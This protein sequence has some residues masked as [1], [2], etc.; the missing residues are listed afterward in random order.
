MANK[1]LVK[2]PINSNQILERMKELNVSLK[3]LSK[4][5]GISDRQ[6]RTY[7]NEQSCP[8]YLVNKICNALPIAPCC[9]ISG[10]TIWMRL[11]VTV[12]VTDEEYKELIEGVDETY[13]DDI[14]ISDDLA[15]IFLSRAI[16]DG[17]SYIPEYC[18][19][20]YLNNYT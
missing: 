16:A 4:R 3:A 1:E 6:L 14:E 15:S 11:G 19:S 17:D 20:S 18:V 7:I 9:A 10:K 12:P 5:I 2:I 13:V 8:S